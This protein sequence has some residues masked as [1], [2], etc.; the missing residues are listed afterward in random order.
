MRVI[1]QANAGKAAALN[2][3]IQA[4]RGDVLVMVDAD[5]VFEEDALARVVQ[6]LGDP[7]VGAVSGNTKVGNRRGLLGRWQHIE[8]VMGFNLD[9]RLYDLLQLHAHSAGAIGAF[10]GRRSRTPAGCRP[11]HSPRTPT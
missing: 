9:R 11:R 3:G 4:A 10:G 1:R 5:T 7:E 2:R 6:P 8:Y